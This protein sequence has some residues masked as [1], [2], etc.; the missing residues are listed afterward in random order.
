MESRP[1]EAS[2]EAS[3]QL[4]KLSPAQLVELMNRE[5]YRTV[6]AVTEASGSI[7]RCLEAIIASFRAGG[8]LFYVG[9]GT[10]GRLGVLDA[11]ECPPTFGVSPQEVQA[12][13]AG[14]PQA[15]VE[16]V[17]GAEDDS[18]AAYRE[19]QAR[20]LK[21]SDFVLGISASGSTPFVVGALERARRQ[22]NKT[23]SIFCNPQAP[24]ARLADYPIL[25]EVGPEV[26]SGSTRLKAGTAT[27]MTLNILSTG[28]MVAQGHV[29]GN[30]MVDV[31]ASNQ[32]L[33]QRQRS[34][35]SQ[36]A[37]VDWQEAELALER[38][39]GDLRRALAQLRMEE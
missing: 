34:I 16:A 30:L 7:S 10:S 32:K 38:A 1:T 31:R 3:T 33:V 39:E 27:K 18:E 28:A 15:L 12:I 9:A 8:R 14:G 22:G 29:V 5:D 37:G 36:L 13:L 24:L 20:G 26:L 19:L 23:G 35:L 25:L 2:N 6:Q 17:E 21:S 4:D 11:A